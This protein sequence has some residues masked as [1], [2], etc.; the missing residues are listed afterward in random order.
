MATS[1][2]LLGLLFIVLVNTA[3]TALATRFFRVRLKTGWGSAVYTALLIPVLLVVLTLAIGSLGIGPNLGSAAAVFGVLYFLPVNGSGGHFGG[4]LSLFILL[5]L[6][7]GIGNGSTFRMIPV[8]FMT[9]HG[10]REGEAPEKEQ[11]R[12]NASKESAA[13][14]GFSSAFAA[15]GAFFIP[16]GFGTSISMTGSPEAALYGFMIFYISCI[17][18]TWWYYS[19]R[20]AP[21]PC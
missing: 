7:T 19:R 11:A 9:L 14:L 3:A 20:K 10:V 4:F 15:Y 17:A 5:F 2:E 1:L 6:T 12:K 13:V 8:I 21:M 16:K 18:M